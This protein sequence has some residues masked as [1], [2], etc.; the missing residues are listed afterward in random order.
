MKIDV[1]ALPNSVQEKELKERIAVV[2]DVLR[3]S[4][5]IITALHNG[6]REVIPLIDIE[7]AIN[8]SKNYEKG[9]FLLGGERNAQKIEGFDLSN[10]PYEYTRDVVEGRTVLI[11]TTN[12]TRA[13][14]K[15]NEAKEVII[16]GFLNAAA[17][18]RY[19]GQKEENVAF[20]CAGTDGKFSLDDILAVGAMIDALQNTGKPLDMDDLGLV[21]LQMYSIH[22]QDL[23]EILKHTYHYKNLVKA[24]FEADVDYCI[25][26]NLLPTIPVYR[27]GV[28]R[29]LN[30]V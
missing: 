18:A 9:T 22:K 3:A 8:L 1:Y 29:V 20:I 11:T 13:I 17:V 15:A 7:E 4:S 30:I 14:R 5:T 16:G 2:V 12:G 19:I 27:E 21:C 25:Q 6:C 26:L 10:S 24:G 28:I 23:K